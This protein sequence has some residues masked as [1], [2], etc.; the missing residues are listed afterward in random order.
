[1]SHPSPTSVAIFISLCGS[2][3]PPHV[4]FLTVVVRNR[5]QKEHPL[6]LAVTLLADNESTLELSRLSKIGCNVSDNNKMQNHCQRMRGARQTR[7]KKCDKNKMGI[8]YA[9]GQELRLKMK[10]GEGGVR[11]NRCKMR[12]NIV[13]E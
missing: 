3:E 1:M 2:F 10:E 7:Q 4:P 13:E 11:G 6:C 8:N 12:E 9:Y 5:R